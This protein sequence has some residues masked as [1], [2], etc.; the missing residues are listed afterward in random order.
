MQRNP[1]NPKEPIETKIMIA[2]CIFA[3]VLVVI[4]IINNSQTVSQTNKTIH[5]SIAS[6]TC[7]CK[8][9]LEEIGSAISEIKQELMKCEWTIPTSTTDL[10]VTE[11][12]LVTEEPNED[13]SLK[14]C[15]LP[16][17]STN[18][19]LFTDYRSYNLWYTPHYRLQQQAYTDVQGLRRFGEDYIVALGSFYSVNIGD[20]F[21]VTLDSGRTFTVIFGDGK[22]DEDCDNRNMYTPCYDLDGNKA[23]N[24]LE[25]IVDDD[26]L[27]KE[28][29]D[30]GSIDIMAG[31]KGDVVKMV[32]LG[33]DN[34]ADWDT[35]ETK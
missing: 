12:A 28:I 30:Y 32:Y 9:E 10:T 19:K 8:D 27:P 14:E 33:R 15:E 21:E 29:Y 4:G 2:F 20:R 5:N 16:N 22:V 17:I 31:F 18:I 6:I 13:H 23:A 35:Y 7:D 24:L 34:S 25:F 11:Q 3:F 26:I 1:R